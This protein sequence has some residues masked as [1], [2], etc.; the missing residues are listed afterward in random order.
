MHNKILFIN[1]HSN[2]HFRPVESKTNSHLIQS[3]KLWLFKQKTQIKRNKKKRKSRY[4]RL[5][6]TNRQIIFF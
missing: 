3:H 6:Q 4:V 5:Y 2:N 1:I